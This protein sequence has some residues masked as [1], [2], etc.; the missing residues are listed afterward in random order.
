MDWFI[1]NYKWI[2]S[3]IGVAAISFFFIRKSVIQKQKSG[4]NSKS[5]MAGRDITYVNKDNND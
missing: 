2:F 3:G 1:G 5:I 4:N